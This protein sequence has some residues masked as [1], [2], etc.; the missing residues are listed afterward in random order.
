M[1][2]IIV[3]ILILAFPFF[4]Y[5]QA[6]SRLPR[7]NYNYLQVSNDVNSG[8]RDGVNVVF[9][10]VPD[11]YTQTI[12]FAVFDPDTGITGLDTGGGATRYTDFYLMG[13]AGC[14]TH[15]N[16][17]LIYYGTP[18]NARTGYEYDYLHA[19][20][21]S[22]NGTWY[23]FTGVSPSAGEHIGNKYY[24]K[25][26]AIARTGGGTFKNAFQVIASSTN[27]DVNNPTDITDIKSFSYN[28]GICLSTLS[29]EWDM[30]PFVNDLD[31]GD[32]VS[33]AWDVDN[34][35]APPAGHRGAIYNSGSTYPGSPAGTLT[36]FAD[37]T[38]AT[39]SFPLGGYVNETWRLHITEGNSGLAQDT[40]E[41]W[42]NNSI[43]STRYYR[44]YSSSYTPPAA[45]H[46]TMTTVDGIGIANNSDTEL[47]TM[48]IVDSLGNPAPYIR[49]LYVTC[50]N[51][52]M[53]NAINGSAV[54]DA[55][56][57]LVTTNTSG[58]A[59]V[60][61]KKSDS[62]PGIVVVRCYW[63][64]TGGSSGFGNNSSTSVTIDFQ[65]SP[66]PII[67]SSAD[68]TFSVGNLNFPLIRIFHSSASAY[69]TTGNDIRLVIPAGLNM[70]FNTTLT[71]LA[72][73]MTLTGTGSVNTTVSYPNSKT[74]L[75]DVT[76]DFGTDSI[77]TINAGAL[78]ATALGAASSGNLGLDYSGDSTPDINDDKT[79]SIGLSITS[80][81]T[82]DF[83]QNGYIDRIQLVFSSNI[84]DATVNPADFTI[85]GVAATGYDTGSTANDNS[86]YIIFA[87]RAL[88]DTGATP[89]VRFIGVNTLQ[90]GASNFLP[91]DAAGVNAVDRAPPI[92]MSCGTRDLNVDG[93]IDAVYITFSENVKDSTINSANFAISGGVTLNV[94]SSTTNGD[95]A[96]NNVIYLTYTDSILTT[97]Q[98]PNITYNPGS[99]ADLNNILLLSY[100]PAASTDTAPPIIT[101]RETAD[102]DGD[103]YIDAMYII[104]SENIDDSTVNATNFA[105]SG[106]VTLNAFNSTTNGDTANDADIYLTFTDGVLSTAAT[107]TVQYTAGT[108]EDLASNLLASTGAVASTDRAGPAILSAVASDA[109]N[110]IAGIDNDD[111]VTIVFSEDT[112]TPVINAGNIDTVF[113]LATH[114][115]LDGSSNITSASWFNSYTLVITLSVSGGVPTVDIGDT[116]TLDGMTITD[117]TNNSTTIAF[118]SITG[119]WYIAVPTIIGAS[120][121]TDNS[122]VD[123]TFSEGVYTDIAGT[124]PVI[125]GDFAIV[126][127]Q[128]GGGATNV[129]LASVTNNTNTALTGGETI[130][131]V[132]LTITGT[133]TGV[134]TIEITPA[135]GT[136]IYDATGNACPATE[137]TGALTLNNLAGAP[138]LTIVRSANGSNR[139]YVQFNMAI[140]D[141]GSGL[142]ITAGN[143]NVSGGLIT[144]AGITDISPISAPRTRYLLTTNINLTDEDILQE[145]LIINNIEND[146]GINI[147]VTVYDLSDIGEYFFSNVV[148]EDAVHNEGDWR[149]TNFDGSEKIS[150]LS[151]RITASV[152]VNLAGYQVTPRLFYAIFDKK[153]NA[154]YWSPVTYTKDKVVSGKNIGGTRWE[155]LLPES[156]SSMT[157]SKIISFV[158]EIGGFYCYRNTNNV[159]NSNFNPNDA[160]TYMATIQTIKKQNNNVTILNNVINPKNNEK[161]SLIY[162]IDK[163]GPV[164]IVVYDLNSDVVK[165]IK[166]ENQNKGTYTVT[167]DGRNENGKIVVRGV[168]FIRVRAPGIFNQ[169]RKILVI[170]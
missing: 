141:S 77:L 111:T 1:K 83:N 93:Y 158:F 88:P 60:N 79:Y 154:T 104:F 143:F 33:H 102:L 89:S 140:R 115:W 170:K 92:I 123:I 29:H 151:I 87:E 31:T 36:G 166:L 165:V 163:D 17:A 20:N 59:T 52:G 58:I 129:T 47:V 122:Y 38:D 147:A 71:N 106:G 118:S 19:N 35:G 40:A 139:I 11:D 34:N 22:S 160:E 125:L 120:L 155:F 144:I 156:S 103:G 14:L 101:A 63:D 50:D 90:D 82:V 116:I 73:V 4:I 23:Y 100:G 169:I 55:A 114:T 56:A 26:V 9:F 91:T 27:T 130:I 2:K 70:E 6:T 67:T 126:F 109:T 149:V 15:A 57:Y 161:A 76:G 54:A 16:A 10:E 99:L 12:Y 94:F 21:A 39:N 64:T 138:L 51:N 157:N 62:T 167:W 112:N 110:L 44:I 13:G 85:D 45:H 37:A 81:Q 105:I 132:H 107:P 133:P 78:Q 42:F 142:D 74:C 3:L 68:K 95:T 162:T 48:Q 148:M 61:V 30:Y 164:S 49:N 134:E 25:I 152:D 137:T 153:S 113:A 18:D 124:N 75:I 136:S 119:S 96:D 69:I 5:S 98:T 108:L 65:A 146:L 72:G 131:R 7:E 150:P 8:D 43:V 159:G 168:Y 53:I 128:N 66:L 97:S 121:A 117:G 84:S 80:R 86:I 135:T 24:F 145:D 127:T 41:F 46:V 32:I 28:W